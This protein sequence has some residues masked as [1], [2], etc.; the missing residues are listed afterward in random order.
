MDIKTEQ[1]TA[2]SIRILHCSMPKI[3]VGVLLLIGMAVG[4]GQAGVGCLSGVVTDLTGS[5]VQDADVQ[6]LN[7]GTNI[8]R[9]MKTSGSGIYSF[10]ALSP[11]SYQLTVTHA[12]FKKATTPAITVEVDRNSS[13]NLELVP[14]QVVETVQVDAGS[15]V[16]L[17]TTD[18]VVGDFI[19]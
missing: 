16:A 6:L 12:G 18:S 19:D 1:A 9:N 7:L 11:G 2:R 4:W 14:G 10:T 17:D 15:Q 5:L 8:T 3:L 13:V